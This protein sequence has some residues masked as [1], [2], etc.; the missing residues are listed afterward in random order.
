MTLANGEVRTGGM[1]QYPLDG[2]FA[3]Y[4]NSGAQNLIFNFFETMLADTTPWIDLR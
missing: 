3:I 4:N 1:I 2:H